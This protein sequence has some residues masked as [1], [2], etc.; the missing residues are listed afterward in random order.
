MTVPTQEDDWR[1]EDDVRSLTEAEAIK[2]DSGR[3]KKAQKMA[4]VMLAEEKAKA[5]A[6]EKI[7]GAEMEYNDKPKGEKKA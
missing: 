6:M 2:A 4:K 3:M 1:A 5:E 7:A